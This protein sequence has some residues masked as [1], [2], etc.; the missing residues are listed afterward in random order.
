MDGLSKAMEEL[1]LKATDIWDELCRLDTDLPNRF[2][3]EFTLAKNAMKEDDTDPSLGLEMLANMGIGGEDI[4][5]IRNKSEIMDQAINNFT[6]RSQELQA[7]V[8]RLEN[9]VAELRQKDSEID[10]FRQEVRSPVTL[11]FIL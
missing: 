9:E 6:T 11:N 4:K 1:E 10:E 5:M 8:K 2:N 7:R 3:E